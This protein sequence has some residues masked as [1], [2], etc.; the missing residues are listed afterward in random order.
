MARR[1]E[2]DSGEELNLASLGVHQTP[3]SPPTIKKMKYIQIE[4]RT[5]DE[6][7]KFED[8]FK[9]TQKIYQRKLSLYYAAMKKEKQ[10][11]NV[12]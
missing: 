9:E 12:S 5:R 11:H 3:K 7:V 4:F 10:N 6:R 1:V 2:A 8:R